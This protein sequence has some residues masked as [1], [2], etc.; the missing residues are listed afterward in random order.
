MPV[1]TV[2]RRIVNPAKKRNSAAGQWTPKQILAGFAGKTAQARALSAAGRAS[3][4][5]RRKRKTTKRSNPS[6]AIR[7]ALRNSSPPQAKGEKTVQRKRSTSTRRRTAAKRRT[8]PASRARAARPRTRTVTK[9]RY[10][11]RRSN[12]VR[13][14]TRRRSNPRQI[15]ALG[16]L[17]KAAM[18]SVGAVGTRLS[19]QAALGSKNT[20]ATGLFANFAASFVLGALISS[21]TRKK[22]DGHMVTIGGIAGTLLRLAQDTTPLGKQASLSGMG[23]VGVNGLGQYAGSNFLYPQPNQGVGPQKALPAAFR[24][25]PQPVPAPATGM[26][27]FNRGRRRSA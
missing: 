20:G 16:M 19:V 8:N 11:T 5:G 21:I 9:Y 15:Q 27:G 24:P 10:R 17:R 13:S 25:Q 7:V 4:T 2:R 1:T 18:V 26:A 22:E 3:S 12:P 14:R 6:Q 23:D